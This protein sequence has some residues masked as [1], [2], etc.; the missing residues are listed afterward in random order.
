[1]ERSSPLAAMHRPAAS[2]GH[3]HWNFGPQ[4]GSSAGSME[5]APPSFDFKELSMK[6]TGPVDYFSL[7]PGK[8]ASP[9]SHLAVDLSRNFHIDKR[10]DQEQSSLRVFMYTDRT[11]SA[12]GHAPSFTVLVDVVWE[13]GLQR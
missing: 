10:Y 13:C 6:N 12:V 5:L 7:K 8:G 4:T 3:G 11:Q 9:T 1:M 2:F